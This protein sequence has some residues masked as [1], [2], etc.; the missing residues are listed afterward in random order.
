VPLDDSIQAQRVLR[1][2]R[3]LVAASNG[4]VKLVRATDVE[5]DTSF[6]SLAAN[7]ER[8]QD[9][10]VSVEWSV[11]SGVDATTAITRE[12]SDWQPHLIAMS[13]R[14][15]SA[16]DRWLN[17]SVTDDIVKAAKVPVLVVPPNWQEPARHERPVRILVPLD[18][19]RFAELALSVV[20]RLA[21]LLT[22]E[23]ML[24][25]VVRAEAE[26]NGAN[27]Y[28]Q[29][30]IAEFES[31]LPDGRLGS[32]VLHGAT[33]TAIT[34]AALD[35]QVDAIAM[36]TRARGG[37]ARALSGNTATTVL[38]HSEV[39]LIIFGPHT[40][41][42]RDSSAQIK[43][44]EP[45]RTRDDHPV[46]EVHRVVVDLEQRAVVSIVVLG[47][48]RLARDV[49]VPIDFLERLDEGEV[50]LKLTAAQFDELPDFSYPEYVTPPSTWTSVPP[51]TE[52]ERLGQH[53]HAVTPETQVVALD[54][55]VGHVNALEFDSETGLLTAFRVHNSARLPAE[56]V[57]ASDGEDVLR[58]SAKLADIEGFVG[59]G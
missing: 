42:E 7:A 30:L 55:Q 56:Y 53:Q 46:G 45:V 5:D 10:G 36:T 37:L 4:H 39:P 11:A 43:L 52:Q 35:L 19:S 49:V 6:N 58:V 12:E 24:V 21:I 8:M 59:R 16:L 20:V 15:E 2:V 1:Y 54:G 14:S 9:D 29:R 50:R 23:I 44:R 28:L 31:V 13:S 51:T 27:E 25:R 32:R 34:Q 3:I 48:D 18:G 57:Q 26:A 40:L 22:A 47:R 41:I 38:E 33:A 17:G